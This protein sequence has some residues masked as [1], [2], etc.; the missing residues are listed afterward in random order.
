[1]WQRLR[2]KGLIDIF[3]LAMLWGP[4]YLFIKI[5]VIEMTPL[6]LATTRITIGALLLAVVLKIKKIRLPRDRVLWFHCCIV[7][8]FVNS[9]P[10]ICFNYSLQTLPTSLSAII[11]GLTPIIT[12]L[13]ANLFLSDE[14]LTL[15]RT[16]GV[17]LGFSGFF[18]LFLPPLLNEHVVLDMRGMMF[19]CLGAT[20]YAIANVYAKK[21]LQNAPAYATP[22]MQ[23]SSSV[24][25]LMPLA[26]LF[27][28]PI[29]CIAEA[30][31]ATW[32]A[33][34]SM[35]F[36]G[37]TLAFMMFYRIIHY[38]GATA[39]AMVTYLLPIIGTILGVVFLKEHI[40]LLFCLAAV[41]IL[42]GVM[43]VNG[44]LT[45]DKGSAR[46]Q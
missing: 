33:I 8:I 11:N 42:G 2:Q 38:Q 21:Y 45:L 9:L 36:F 26:F 39:V 17:I 24:V 15:N 43:M 18:V 37:T 5:A 25:Y 6:T 41:L 3:T 23:L 13:L 10:F 30:S 1:M 27:D 40:G 22:L 7:G 46:K 12:L 34:L 29:Q 4:S 14:R 44:A 35:A 32:G 28:S 19:S 20:S 31:W 16:I